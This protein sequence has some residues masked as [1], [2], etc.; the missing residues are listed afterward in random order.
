M[1]FTFKLFNSMLAF[2]LSTE[3]IVKLNVV[4]SVLLRNLRCSI[5]ELVRTAPDHTGAAYSNL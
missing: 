4:H 3:F 2:T 5:A 1:I